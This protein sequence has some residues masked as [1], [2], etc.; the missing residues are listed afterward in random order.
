MA[1]LTSKG[2]V[3][4]PMAVRKAMGAEPGDEILFELD[5]EGAR[6]HVLKRVPLVELIGILPA[7]RPYTDWKTMREE[8]GRALGAE[9]ERRLKKT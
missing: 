9:L 7:T 6:V 5:K 4:I 3:T 8:A 1:R 2:Q